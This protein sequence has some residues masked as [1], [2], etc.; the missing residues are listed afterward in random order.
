MASRTIPGLRPHSIAMCLLNV[1]ILRH[2]DTIFRVIN[3]G[4]SAATKGTLCDSL[5]QLTGQ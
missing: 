3:E 4:H 1:R 5:S 2:S